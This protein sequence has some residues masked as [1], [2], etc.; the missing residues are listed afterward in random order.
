MDDMNLKEEIIDPIIVNEGITLTAIGVGTAF[1]VLLTLMVVVIFI[2]LMS[3]MFARISKSE[4]DD[5]NME[6]ERHKG[7]AAA[8]A[9]TSILSSS[10]QK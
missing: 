9:V 8:I 3:T 7:M 2:S 10:S 5:A 1:G 4:H 6:E